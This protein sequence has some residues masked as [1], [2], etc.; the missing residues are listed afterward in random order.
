[1]WRTVSQFPRVFRPR[2]NSSGRGFPFLEH[3]EF[4]GN[5]EGQS[6]DA[7]ISD[8]ALDAGDDVD[9]FYVDAA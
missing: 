7:E 5:W 9:G 1:M 3:F 2:C 6:P 8:G 4:S